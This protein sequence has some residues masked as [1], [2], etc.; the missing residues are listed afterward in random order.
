VIRARLQRV[1]RRVGLGAAGLGAALV[2]FGDAADAQPRKPVPG[3]DALVVEGETGRP[4]GRLVIAL[5]SEPKTLNPLSAVDRTSKEVLACLMSDLIHINRYSQKTEPALARKWETSRDARHYT[6]RLRRDLVFSDG[7]PA[8]ADDVLFTFRAYMD[9]T[10]HSPQRDLLIV[11]GKPI[12]LRKVDSQT[13]A[14]DLAQ[15]YAAVERLFDG[16]AILPRHLLERPYQEGRLSQAWGLGT[17]P[18]QIAGLGPFRLKEY[19]PG[20]RLVL[21]RNPHYWKVDAKGSR[22]PYL[23]ELTFLFV[24]SEDAQVLRFQAG[25]TDLISALNAENFAALEPDQQK[26]GY[27]LH[28]LGPGL[29]Y[30]FLFFNLNDLDAKALGP[31]AR[32]QSW[33]RQVAF[34]KAVS[35]AIDRDAIVSL[36]F[37][38]RATPLWSHV[39][40]GNRLWVNDRL[41]RPPRSIERA[42]Q[43]LQAAG[44]SW[45]T[46][47]ALMD[48][49]GEAV[50]FSI[51]TNAANAQRLK[52]ATLIQDDLKQIG[53]RVQVVPFENRAMLNRIL[54][55]HEYEACLLGLGSGDADP[56]GEMNVWPSSGSTHL[57][58]L[59][60]VQPSTPWEA[61]ID[62]LMRR[63]LVTV[64]YEERKKLYDRVQELVAE[65]L[66]VICLV[67]PNILVG[68]K[69]GLGHFL[70][71]LLDPH[72]LWNVDQLFWRNPSTRGP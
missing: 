3:E 19:V 38:G 33:F 12:E 13:V 59:G 27:R 11:S 17:P 72:A 1:L 47:G 29:E 65:N 16:F 25:E 43:L 54:Q 56:N 62:A 58:H 4:G 14:F 60:Q 45:R 49:S 39:T 34:R 48:Q 35:A 32:K 67:G 7:H 66:P 20:Q 23:D 18:G 37:Q 8:D 9:E 24:S 40:A 31:V 28:D 36:A 69:E 21:E 41:P 52:I 26:R 64:R 53:M 44:F 71:A 51:L 10:V 2:L 50:E 6:L 70:P 55:T 63:Q 22:L 30:A 57:W 5:R 42:R 68:A 15:P 61:E 46:D